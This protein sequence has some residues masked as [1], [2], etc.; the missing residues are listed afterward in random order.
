MQHKFWPWKTRE[1][2]SQMAQNRK[3]NGNSIKWDITIYRK[4]S[5]EKTYRAESM[6][7]K[8]GNE[9]ETYMQNSKQWMCISQRNGARPC[10]FFP[11]RS[12]KV[13]NCWA[14]K[15]LV[16]YSQLLTENAINSFEIIASKYELAPGNTNVKH[17]STSVISGHVNR[18]FFA[19]DWFFF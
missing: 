16:T 7:F 11:N 9:L 1:N 15:G 8:Y 12:D 14:S 4:S 5:M 2:R 18:I 10:F 6:Y 19:I 3:R 17:L 13:L